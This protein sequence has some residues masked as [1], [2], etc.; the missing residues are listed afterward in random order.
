MSTPEFSCA[1]WRTSS[2][3]NGERDCVEVAVVPG[4]VGVRDSKDRSGPALVFG[5]SAWR[6]FVGDVQHSG[7]DCG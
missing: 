2:R 3:S 7:F 5:P 6:A 4:R 1:V